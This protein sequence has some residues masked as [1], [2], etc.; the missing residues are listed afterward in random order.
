MNLPQS[1]SEMVLGSTASNIAGSSPNRVLHPISNRTNL[2]G[3]H[4]VTYQR[5]TRLGVA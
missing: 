4:S 2:I 1:L 5:V 3:L